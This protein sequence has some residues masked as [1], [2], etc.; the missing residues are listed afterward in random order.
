MIYIIL[1]DKIVIKKKVV[2]LQP[3]LTFLFSLR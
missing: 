2:F 1:K 3:S